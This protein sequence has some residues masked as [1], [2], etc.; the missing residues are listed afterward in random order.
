[1]CCFKIKAASLLLLMLSFLS[2]AT[3]PDPSSF[4]DCPFAQSISDFKSAKSR[5]ESWFKSVDSTGGLLHEVFPNG[6]P[7]S[8]LDYNTSNPKDAYTRW[9]NARHAVSAAG[10][11]EIEN[12]KKEAEKA[13]K[14]AEELT[15]RVH[16]ETEEKAKLTSELTEVKQKVA[17]TEELVERTA[18]ADLANNNPRFLQVFQQ[19][20]GNQITF[21]DLR[22]LKNEDQ[23]SLIIPYRKGEIQK[24]II[25]P[26]DSQEELNRELQQATEKAQGGANT[27]EIL[28]PLEGKSPDLKSLIEDEGIVWDFNNVKYQKGFYAVVL[29]FVWNKDNGNDS[30]VFAYENQAEVE[31]AFQKAQLFIAVGKAK[32]A[33]G[34]AATYKIVLNERPPKMEGEPP[35]LS[36]LM[37]SY[38]YTVEQASK[39][40]D[41]YGRMEGD[42]DII[43]RELV[44]SL[45][46]L[47][48]IKKNLQMISKAIGKQEPFH[49]VLNRLFEVDSLPSQN[50]LDVPGYSNTVVQD[51]VGAISSNPQNLTKE[52]INDAAKNIVKRYGKLLR[53]RNININTGF[54]ES[55]D[56]DTVAIDSAEHF[57]ERYGFVRDFSK[58]LNELFLDVNIKYYECL[59]NLQRMPALFEGGYFTSYVKA[60]TDDEKT[61][62]ERI[63]AEEEMFIDE[64][65]KS[66]LLQ[67][68]EKL[69]GDEIQQLA[70]NSDTFMKQYFNRKQSIVLSVKQYNNSFYDQLLSTPSCFIFMQDP[71]YVFLTLNDNNPEVM[72]FFA[73][74]S[75]AQDNDSKFSKFKKELSALTN[76][77]KK[78]IFLKVVQIENSF[79]SLEKQYNKITFNVNRI[80]PVDL[81]DFKKAL[82]SSIDRQKPDEMSHT[83]KKNIH[84]NA[85]L[86]TLIRIYQMGMT[87][88]EDLNRQ[89]RLKTLSG[90]LDS[91]DPAV[92]LIRRFSDAESFNGIL[93]DNNQE[94]VLITYWQYLNDQRS[95]EERIQQTEESE[96]DKQIEALKAGKRLVD[97]WQ[98]KLEMSVSVSNSSFASNASKSS[99]AKSSSGGGGVSVEVSSVASGKLNLGAISAKSLAAGGGGV[100]S[101][102]SSKQNF[103]ASLSGALNSGLSQKAKS[104][105]SAAAEQQSPVT[106]QGL[107][108]DIQFIEER[109]SAYAQSKQVDPT[110]IPLFNKYLSILTI[111]VKDKLLNIANSPDPSGINHVRLVGK[112]IKTMREILENPKV[113]SKKLLD[114]IPSVEDN[115]EQYGTDAAYRGYKAALEQAKQLLTDLLQRENITFDDLGEVD[116]TYEKIKE[117]IGWLNS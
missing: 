10:A 47:A 91:Q 68:Q 60:I 107:L 48:K 3:A 106:A 49:Q 111:S 80:K 69:N 23:W 84:N 14:K 22:E 104:T 30:L 44:P 21:Q 8:K 34:G 40:L 1:M 58:K 71:I 89:L 110:N 52:L 87:N 20:Q 70:T 6:L 54:F 67:D 96:I 99:S 9:Y 36:S 32:A 26:F 79:S 113:F 73:D 27:T 38:Y 53:R 28:Q 57:Y 5:I 92:V 4:P 46:I 83:L 50:I 12:A 116:A 29:P 117:I 76:V 25:I 85:S 94:K 97:K 66:V 16:Q 63:K 100:S 39:I 62:R 93:G 45:Q 95:A 102:A 43:A 51:V 103:A 42:A 65:K 86:S 24:K 82:L 33:G 64:C 74:K 55:Q 109:I 108:D 37:D 19:S 31:R 75:N 61:I 98:K 81:S 13:R 115:L 17:A 56:F 112:K 90:L 7:E 78:I 88:L 2:A 11:A 72:S 101:S 35:A 105:K 15:N 59:K 114:E 18:G 77:Q 41:E